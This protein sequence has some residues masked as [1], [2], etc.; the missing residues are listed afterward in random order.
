MKINNMAEYAK[1][2]KY[3]VAR[4]IEGELWFY[5]AWDDRDQANEAALEIEGI[6]VENK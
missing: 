1:N 6:T 4:E 5:G 2:R 3:I